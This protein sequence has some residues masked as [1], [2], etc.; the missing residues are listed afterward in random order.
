MALTKVK[1]SN[2]DDAVL[3]V[4]D[5]SLE[6]DEKISNVMS[7]LVDSSPSTL[8]TIKEISDALGDDANHV[9]AMTSLIDAKLSPTGDGSQLQ[10]LP[11][12]GGVIEAVASGTLANGDKVILQSDGTVKVV[13]IS[14]T[15]L[16]QAVGSETVFNT[17]ESNYTA[18]TFD[19]NSNKIVIAYRDSGNSNYGTAMV[20]TIS[21]NS[22]SFGS[23]YIFNSGESNYD[24][25][26]FDSN[27]N[28]VVIAYRDGGNLDY[29]HAIVGTVSGNSISF[30]SETVFYAANTTHIAITF[31]SNSNKVVIALTNNNTGYGWGIVGTVSG[32]S[33]SF[34]SE[35]VFNSGSTQKTSM[36]FDSNSNKVVIAYSDWGN[37]SRGTSIVGTVSGTSISFGSET[38][39]NSGSTDHT[40]TTFDSNSNKVVIAYK[41]EGNSSYGTAIVGTVSG[42]SI[43]FG[44]EAVFNSGNS[45]WFSAT[46]DPNVNKIVIAYGDGGNSNRGTGVVGTVS[47]TSI[48]FGSEV[49][50]NSGSTTYMGSAF[51][52]NLNKSVMVYQDTGNLTYGT[53]VVW[54]NAGAYPATN[55]TTD[56]YIGISDGAYSDTATATIQVVGATDD[57]QSGLTTGSK[58]YVQENGTLGTTPAD[59]SVYAG[60]A[61]SATKLLI[62]G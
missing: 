21:G 26:T 32:T 24:A 47:G 38:V 55:L 29:G 36:T 54:R 16:D 41:D 17:A 61:L 23:E 59:P 11:A 9:T 56:N 40:A 1:N 51:D 57:A 7:E 37:S 46:F 50:F 39:F 19:S 42:T 6:V 52:S 12:S 4:Y 48:T 3:D 45:S 60:I 35:T 15:Q 10:N 25:I 14:S 18:A 8:N 5:T 2:L 33:I 20:G 43:S 58:H 62:K 22:I 30:G 49:V 28:K 53:A 31:D 27:S 34:G 13:G 44:S